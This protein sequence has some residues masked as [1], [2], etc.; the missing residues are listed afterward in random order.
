M[1]A[2]RFFG[3]VAQVPGNE[4]HLACSQRPGSDGRSWSAPW[5]L[6]A[7]LHSAAHTPSRPVVRLIHMLEHGRALR[8][9]ELFVVLLRQP[10]SECLFDRQLYPGACL[11]SLR[12][13]QDQLLPLEDPC[14]CLMAM[15]HL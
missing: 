8:V 12:P 14:V 5:V 1:D 9:V 11:L 15:G 13:V 10:A 4:G 3:P 2:P 6:A 7:L